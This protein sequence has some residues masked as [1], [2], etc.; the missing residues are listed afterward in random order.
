[1][2]EDNQQVVAI[3]PT[4]KMLPIFQRRSDYPIITAP[5]GSDRIMLPLPEYRKIRGDA[6]YWRTLFLFSF[7]AFCGFAFVVLMKPPITVKEPF[8]V[9]KQVPVVVPGK[10]VMFC[11]K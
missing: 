7:V 8:V 10:C 1:M 3:Q 4:R 11:S 6:G 9:E 5:D 2:S